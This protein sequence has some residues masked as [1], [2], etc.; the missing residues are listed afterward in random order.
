M[1]AHL[2]RA[3]CSLAVGSCT[4]G[5]LA[6]QPTSEARGA[7]SAEAAA[8]HLEARAEPSRRTN[9]AASID[10]AANDEATAF[11]RLLARDGPACREAL[12]AAGVK[13]KA[14][15]D[16]DAVG[17]NGCGMPFGV[18]L[19]RGPTGVVYS[20]PLTV[21]CSFASALV[22]VEQ[23][24]QEVA[25]TTVGDKIV[26]IR[27]LGGFACRSQRGRFAKRGKL[28]EHSF[29]NAAD[30][31]EFFFAKRR[32][33]SVLRH[34]ERDASVPAT[35]QGRFLRGAEREVRRSGA[36][37]RVI[38]PAWDPMHRDHFHIDSGRRSWASQL[39][40]YVWP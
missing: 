32:S 28:S 29:G 17:P 15:P 36:V 27:S 8:A 24:L 1:P 31:A 2:A 16:R 7:G 25:S 34:Y 13:F 33:A 11:D 12:R 23:S 26:R 35:A 10:D 4:Q 39:R 5:P 22:E 3:L 6:A 30:F 18:I 37:S 9:V 20:P 21:D 19:S 40:R 38:G 14:L